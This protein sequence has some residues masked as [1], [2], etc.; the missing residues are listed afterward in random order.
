MFLLLMGTKD[1]KIS[2]GLFKL[3]QPS[4]SSSTFPFSVCM[5]VFVQGEAKLK[6][7]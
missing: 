4:D 7:S 3:F 6:R 1:M 5:F 2:S